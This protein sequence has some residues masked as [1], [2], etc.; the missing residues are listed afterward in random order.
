MRD[1][2]SSLG[3][4]EDSVITQFSDFIQSSK[5]RPKFSITIEADGQI[6]RYALE[7]DKNGAKSGAYCLHL[8]GYTP[9]GFVMDWHDK[10]DKITWKY[11]YTPEQRREYGRQMHST[12]SRIKIDAERKERERLKAQELKLQKEKQQ[13]AVKMAL[14]E[15][16]AAER[17]AHET[18]IYVHPY[19]QAK[20]IDTGIYSDIL[21]LRIT[22][23]YR[24]AKAHDLE[25]YQGGL[26]KAGE[27]LIPM[28]NVLT[29]DFQSLIHI[30]TKQTERGFMKLIYTGTSLTG[31]A[32][33]LF[34]EQ[35]MN[36]DTVL[37]CEG[38]TTALSV[39]VIT[40]G[41]LPV[42][43]AGTCHN[44]IHVCKGL[45]TRYSG[46]RILVMADHD[47]AGLKAAHECISA[48]VADDFQYPPNDGEDFFDF[49]ARKVKH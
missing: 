29:G 18:Y 17:F 6:H 13:Q 11:E 7:R 39:L 16:K 31:A 41:K 5:F 34:T 40:G 30:P 49:L 26:C 47:E 27:L 42:F 24:I 48:G 23:D 36:A 38:I 12:E 46:K 15:Y 33:W 14:T 20:F 45:R 2:F 21:R 32:H 8:N 3:V 37:A 25:P 19:F 43:S 35:S 4:S 10:S 1:Y 28:R 9:A 44:L 22:R